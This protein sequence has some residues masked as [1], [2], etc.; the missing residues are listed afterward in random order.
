[1]A[2]AKFWH[3]GHVWRALHFRWV[4]ARRRRALEALLAN[5]MSPDWRDTR[6]KKLRRKL[7]LLPP[8]PSAQSAMSTQSTPL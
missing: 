8:V 5:K 7:G 2:I 3:L 4:N 6:P 1:M